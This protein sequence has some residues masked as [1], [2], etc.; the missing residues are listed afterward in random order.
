[1][2][3]E[4]RYYGDD[5]GLSLDRNWTIALAVSFDLFDGGRRRAE[6]LQARAILDQLEARDQKAL[7]DV[8]LD[9]ETSYLALEEARARLDV[10]AQAVSAAEETLEL[11]ETQYRGGGAP[12]TRYLEA[13]A[14]RTGARTN[15]IRAAL[16]L[17]RAL[18]DVHRALGRLGRE[19]AR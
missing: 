7:L 18:V 2:D 17:D 15:R 16:D 8:A 12:I 11:V 10:A 9:V 3:V 4:A 6:V 5:E 19:C 14:A 13:E 1:V